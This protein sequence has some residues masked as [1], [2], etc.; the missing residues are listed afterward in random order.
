M[1]DKSINLL[2]ELDNL[3]KVHWLEREDID[4]IMLDFATQIVASLKIERVSVWLYNQDRT[5]LV[6]MG[7]YD[8]RTRELKK[9]SVLLKSDYPIYFKALETNK[10]ILAENI[11]NNRATKEL[12][13][14]YAKPLQVES[15]MDIPIRIA[16]EVIGVLCFEK[17]GAKRRFNSKEQSF[18]LSVSFVLASTLE[19]RHRRAAQHKL[20]KALLEKDLLIKEINHRVK[21]SFAI[22]VSLLRISKNR[23][24]TD[25]PSVLMEEYEQ[26]IMSMIK[27]HDMLD[28]SQNHT[29]INL[30]E[31]LHELV[32]EFKRAHPSIENGIVEHIDIVNNY[33]TTR[34]A[35]HIG[36]IVTEIFLNSIKYGLPGNSD[37]KLFVR[38]HQA[39]D[40]SIHIRIGDNGKGFDFNEKLKITTLGIHLIK[41]LAEGMELLVS[42]PTKTENMYAFTLP[43]NKKA[44]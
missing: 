41:D 37:Y 10:I 40:H 27:I 29:N 16:G 7:E 21:N 28:L 30:S 42:Y 2:D 38:L 35:M 17:V 22:L 19:A 6:S 25:N 26:R 34:E 39:N 15:L 4:N 12:S 3:S 24:K 20:D 36:L 43:A 33:L 5:S 8:I 44:D 18:A 32:K 9:D 23:G 31:Y 13:I 1:V 14:P 11:H